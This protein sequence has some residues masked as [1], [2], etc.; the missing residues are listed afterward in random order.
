MENEIKNYKIYCYV[1]KKGD[2][3]YAATPTLNLSSVGNTLEHAREKLENN[4]TSYFEVV[5]NKNFN[6]EKDMHLLKRKAPLFMYR[7]FAICFIIT[8]LFKIKRF[9]E[10]EIDTNKI[11]FNN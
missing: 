1:M 10:F 3:F 6:P 2:R 11:C 9:F 7:D 8:Y 5:C 4:I